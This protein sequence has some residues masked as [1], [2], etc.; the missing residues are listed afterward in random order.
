MRVSTVINNH[1]SQ[2]LFRIEFVIAWD[3]I[4]LFIELFE[5]IVDSFQMLVHTKIRS[6]FH[7]NFSAWSQKTGAYESQEHGLWVKSLFPR[8]GMLLCI[9]GFVLYRICPVSVRNKYSSLDLEQI[10]YWRNHQECHLQTGAFPEDW[11]QKI[12]CSSSVEEP[13]KLFLLFADSDADYVVL[14]LIFSRHSKLKNNEVI[15]DLSLS[16]LC[17]G[18]PG[19]HLHVPGLH[20]CMPGLRLGGPRL[21]LDTPGLHLDGPGLHLGGPE[22]CLGGPGLCLGGPRLRLN[23]PEICLSRLGL[24]LGGLGLHSGMPELYFKF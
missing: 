18:G 3:F 14:T 22:L 16:R 19:L 9:T 17:L 2:Q 24:H 11:V 15:S 6:L 23:W 20:L 21:C 12:L 4:S 13:C 10:W 7:D 5:V 8:V 1:R